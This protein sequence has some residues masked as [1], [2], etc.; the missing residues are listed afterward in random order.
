MS[1]PDQEELCEGSHDIVPSGEI[2]RARYMTECDAAVSSSENPRDVLKR[3]L[4]ARPTLPAPSN[5]FK[6]Q[7]SER[8]ETDAQLRVIGLGSCASVFEEP[9]TDIAYKKGADTEAIQ[10]DRSLTNT[11][12]T[13]LVDARTILQQAFPTITLPQTPMC[14]EFFPPDAKDWWNKNLSRFSHEHRFEGIMLVADRIPP[15]PQQAREA[16]I[17][18]YFDA[19]PKVQEDAM[20][21]EENRHCL[22]RLYPGENETPEE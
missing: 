2:A 11:V 14:H 3:M 20:T 4:L 16:L 5:P 18:M 7:V 13:A 22:I 6:Y 19:S 1:C 15:L 8:A 10:N 17:E 9:G 12:H 21:S